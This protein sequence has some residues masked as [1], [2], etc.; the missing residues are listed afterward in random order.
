MASWRRRESE[1]LALIVAMAQRIVDS[2]GNLTD[3]AHGI[4]KSWETRTDLYR[5]IELCRM[6]IVGLYKIHEQGKEKHH[7]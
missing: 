3:Q 1:Q 4:E 6:A 7:A 5:D 2:A